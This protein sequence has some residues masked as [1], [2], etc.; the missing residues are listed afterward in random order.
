MKVV[1][2]VPSLGREFGG[3]AGKA[4]DL[5]AALREHGLE[6]TL[7][8]AGDDGEEGSALGRIAHYHATPVPRRWRPLIW[9]VRGADIV[10][11]L[12]FRDPVG[13]AA[14]IEA[15][16]ARVPY[17]VEPVGM[18][19]RRLR[20][21]VLKRVFDATF[22]RAIIGRAAVLVAA[23]SVEAQDIARSGV[24]A[25]RIRVRPNGVR[26][27]SL[28]PRPER[29]RLRDVLGIPAKVPLVVTLARFSASKGLPIL[30]EAVAAVPG[31]HALLAGPDEHDGT[32]EIVRTMSERIAGGRV[33]LVVGGLWGEDR[34]EAVAEANVFCLPSAFESFGTAAAEAAGVGI[35]VVCTDRCGVKDVLL[36]DSSRIVPADDPAAL[37]A[38]LAEV[39]ADGRIAAAARA[40]AP[41]VRSHLDWSG[42]VRSQVAIYEEVLAG[43]GRRRSA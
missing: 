17:V 6:V 1:L 25:D 14:A 30:V 7:F 33:H 37:A 24:P 31:L 26:F 27:D 3:P 34:A 38:A 19:E 43:L 21:I 32:L 20:S 13:T 28:V 42:L 8:A 16:R 41:T 12:G 40:S 2:T 23:S 11:V 35:P 39:T 18:L 4:R 10:H 22:G 15:R 5:A 9:A 29:G 36:D